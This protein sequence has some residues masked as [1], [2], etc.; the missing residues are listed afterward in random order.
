M[1]RKCVL[2]E[3]ARA[4]DDRLFRAGII[5][6]HEGELCQVTELAA[7][8]ENKDKDSDWGSDYAQAAY[9]PLGLLTI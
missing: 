6:F 9:V 4:G 2:Y 5:F 7:N 3:R 8:Q 1:P